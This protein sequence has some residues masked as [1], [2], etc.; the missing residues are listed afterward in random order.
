M[1]E[2]PHIIIYWLE[3]FGISYFDIEPNNANKMNKKN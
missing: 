3:E 2:S 1:Y